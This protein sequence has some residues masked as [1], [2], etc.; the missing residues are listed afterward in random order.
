MIIEF[1]IQP[2]MILVKELNYLRFSHAS[3]IKRNEVKQPNEEFFHSYPS[4]T[5]LTLKPRLVYIV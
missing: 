2:F 5:Q 1:A 4:L 3:R